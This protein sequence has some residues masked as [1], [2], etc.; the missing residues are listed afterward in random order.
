MIAEALA[1]LRSE[2]ISLRQRVASLERNSGKQIQAGR[3]AE[4]DPDKG[5]RLDMGDAGG[6]Q[7][8][9]PWL[10]HPEQGGE[11]TSW[12]PPT[13]GQV[14]LMVTPYGDNTEKAYVVRAG[15]CDEFTAP[16]RN[17]NENVFNFGDV[18]LTVRK[19]EFEIKVGETKVVFEKDKIKLLSELIATIGPTKLGLDTEQEVENEFPVVETVIAPAKQTY[20]KVS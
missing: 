3:V 2:I 5:I 10:P 12:V 17:L 15:Y 20:A 6:E 11:A 1:E 9:T 18:R 19:E 14:L 8:L 13:V 7:K 4:V 16:V